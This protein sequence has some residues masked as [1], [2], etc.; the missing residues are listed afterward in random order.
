MNFLLFGVFI[1]SKFNSSTTKS[2]LPVDLILNLTIDMKKS[3][4]IKLKVRDILASSPSPEAIKNKRD[5]VLKSFTKPEFNK[6]EAFETIVSMQDMMRDSNTILFEKLS[7]YA[8]T[9]NSPERKYMVYQFH[10]VRME[11]IKD[12]IH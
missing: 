8:M 4:E 9:L 7:D 3:E 6:Q 12:L 2:L 11:K 10:K 5:Q 1:A